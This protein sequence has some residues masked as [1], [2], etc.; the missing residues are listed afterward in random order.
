MVPVDLDDGLGDTLFHL[1]HAVQFFV[2]YP[3][4]PL[5]GQWTPR[6]GYSSTGYSS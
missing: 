5:P 2:Q 6:N 1:L 4:L 3:F